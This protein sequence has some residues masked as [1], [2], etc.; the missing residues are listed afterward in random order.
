MPY[1]YL[2]RQ[3]AFLARGHKV[4]EAVGVMAHVVAYGACAIAVGSLEAVNQGTAH[5]VDLDIDIA[6][7][8]L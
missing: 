6:C 1:D 2:L 8:M 5:V 3:G 7:Q 4:I